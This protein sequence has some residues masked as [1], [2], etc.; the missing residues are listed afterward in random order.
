MSFESNNM[1]TIHLGNYEEFFILY[2]DNE[3]SKEQVKMV[4][5]F[6]IANPDLRAEFEILVSTKLPLEEFSFN[7]RDLFAENMNLS[8]IDEELLLYIDNELPADKKKI[9][10][11]E[12]ASNK[13][14]Q[15]QHKALV[16]TKLDR[17]EKIA[18][19]NKKELYH[20]TEKVIALKVW[21]RI[22]VAVVIIAVSGIVYFK[23]P[24]SITPA[25]VIGNTG[26][27]STPSKNGVKTNEAANTAAVPVV[28]PVKIDV[29]TDN[30][31]N[32]KYRKQIVV[33]NTKG[34]DEDTPVEQN[35]IAEL[36]SSEKDPAL[37]R[38][39]VN[40]VHTEVEN[41][42]TTSKNNLNTNPV[43]NLDPDRKSITSPEEPTAQ[44][45]NDR[46]GSLKGFLR[47]ATRMIEKRTGI[48]P[49][50]ANGELLIGAVAIN[51]K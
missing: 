30:Q 4:D 10:E 16:Q 43:T 6:L 41:N 28:T 12:L 49:T 21:M 9:V 11:L 35:L 7:K 44:T 17:S 46:K 51:L 23:N 8:A 5:D 45:D 26:L 15:L 31:N 13:D 18:Y 32:K 37:E 27:T 48:D 19:P 3:L 39:R 20:R 36:T 42:S 25:V 40:V 47:K 22:A 24:P 2:M 34:K 29:A 38:T 14:Y 33:A 1:N 50:N